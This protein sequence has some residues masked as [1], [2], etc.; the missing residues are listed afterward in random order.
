[1]V[2]NYNNSPHT[3]LLGRIPASITQHESMLW[4]KMYV[5]SLKPKPVIKKVRKSVLKPRNYK[6][7]VGDHVRLS[8]I[9]HPFERDYQEK[10]TEEVFIIRE[11][12]RRSN[13]PIYKDWD[14]EEVKGTWYESELQKINK[15][16]DNLWKIESVL[17]KR[18]RGG[19]TE[20]YVKWMGWPK[21]FNSLVSENE[22]KDV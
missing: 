18:K 11:M 15:D 7:K 8:H 9:K 14:G 10:W 21:K 4:K 3:S 12:F 22:V 1:M 19:R 6:F 5:D 20:L 16:N 2:T 13:I 17:K